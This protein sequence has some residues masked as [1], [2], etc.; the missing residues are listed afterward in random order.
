MLEEKG[1]SVPNFA[2]NST[3]STDFNVTFGHLISAEIMF[4]S[5][6]LNYILQG[7]DNIIFPTKWYSEL[8]FLTAVQLQQNWAYVNNVNVLAAGV[9]NP[10]IG[11]SGSGIYSGRS[12]ALVS[13]MTG[14]N[15]TKVLIHEV[16]K[17]PGT[18]VRTNSSVNG[19]DID[20][21]KLK[22]DQIE[23]Y[24]LKAIKMPKELNKILNDSF[25]LCHNTSKS[26]LCCSFEIGV[27]LQSVAKSSVGVHIDN[28]CVVIKT[29]QL[30][31]I[32]YVH[33]CCV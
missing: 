13:L 4:S 23:K 6:G 12:G 29:F 33:G 31:G 28:V 18:A 19:S 11:C 24:K 3:F 1:V 16:P 30:S 21:L 14:A 2:D 25:T 22:Q 8:P 5:P 7:V 20:N 10:S 26:E 32:L 9:N 15:G 27:T 17:K